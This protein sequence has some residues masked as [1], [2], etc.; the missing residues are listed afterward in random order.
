MYEHV[1][2]E[3]D[4]RENVDQIVET[5]HMLRVDSEMGYVYIEYVEPDQFAF[6]YPFCDTETRSKS[7]TVRALIG[8]EEV[9][10]LEK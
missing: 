6:H 8:P 2:S 7:R 5:E 3:E 1:I 4:A 10:L 9:T